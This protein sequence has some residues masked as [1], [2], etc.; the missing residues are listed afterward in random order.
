MPGWTVAQPVIGCG[1]VQGATK[2]PHSGSTRRGV[3]Q[4]QLAGIVR[5]TKQSY[6]IPG[7]PRYQVPACDLPEGWTLEPNM[8]RE[9]RPMVRFWLRGPGGRYRIY[10]D[11]GDAVCDEMRAMIAEITM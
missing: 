3:G 10:D 6:H 1:M 9:E 4:A 8:D 11:W 2:D 5:M 7:E